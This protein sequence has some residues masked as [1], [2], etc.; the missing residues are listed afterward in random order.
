MRLI[1]Q[2]GRRACVCGQHHNHGVFVAGH[3]GK[4][5]GHDGRTAACSSATAQTSPKLLNFNKPAKRAKGFT[6][7]LQTGCEQTV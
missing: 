2:I 7:V 4:G 6:E 3:A 1:Q 5:R